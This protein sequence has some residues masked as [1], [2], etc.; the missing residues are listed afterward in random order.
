MCSECEGDTNFVLYVSAGDGALSCSGA[1]A[2]S[3]T[4]WT[5]SRGVF[6]ETRHQQCQQNKQRTLALKDLWKLSLP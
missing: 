1:Q 3:V 2:Y 4:V 6:C 5:Q